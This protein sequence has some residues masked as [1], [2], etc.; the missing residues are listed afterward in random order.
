MSTAAISSSSIYQQTEQYSQ[1]RQSDLQQLGQAL[2]SGGLA[3]AGRL[4]TI[5]SSPAGAV[6]LPA[7]THSRDP[8]ASRILQLSDKHCSRA[9][10]LEPK[11]P[12]VR[13]KAR[14]K[15]GGH[16][17]LFQLRFHF[18]QRAADYPQPQ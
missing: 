4:T 18:Q 12:S 3:G 10:W 2:Q 13:C 15:R 14:F 8:S 6:R 11:Q 9:I 17:K 1:T 7:E 16:A 5:S